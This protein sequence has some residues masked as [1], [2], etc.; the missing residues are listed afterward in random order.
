MDFSK[1][2]RLFERACR[3]A[4]GG[5]NSPVRAFRSVGGNPLFVSQACG[6]R[7]ETADG[8]DLIDF[9]GSWGPLILGHAHPAVVEAISEAAQRGT[10]FGI[11]T[12]G[13]VE[14]AEFLCERIPY[15][16]KIRLVNSGTE[17]VMTGIRLARGFTGRNLLIKFAGG[18]HGHLDALLVEAGSGLLTGGTGSSA[19]VPDPVASDTFVAPFNDL[20]AVAEIIRSRGNEL[21]A[22]I[23]EP[24]AGNMGLVPPQDGFLPGLRR[25]CDRVGALLI[26]D[27]VITGFRLGPTTY[28][29]L[30]GVR[31][32]LTAL[33]KIIGGGLPIGAIGGRGDIMDHLAPDGPVYQAG[34]LSGNPVAVAAG[35]A[36]LRT[37]VATDPYAL[38][39][40][41]ASRLAESVNVVAEDMGLPMHVA[42]LGGM[43]TPFH[44]LPP[45]NDQTDA[46]RADLQAFRRFWKTMLRESIYLPPSQFEVAFVS[47]AHTDPDID[48]TIAAMEVALQATADVPG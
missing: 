3:V 2:E 23:V 21:A 43:F 9:C 27:E 41:K 7:I 15:L 24:V 13:E 28:G 31:P 12:E 6:A 30:V 38:L 45:V 40:D 8:D 34:T 1:S 46:K 5:V 48:E 39:A 47:A 18:Y 44:T 29:A 33:G 20:E 14:L 17:A 19:G 32:D 25:L 26:F 16:E 4:P 22:V 42:T 36:T 11:P 10:S 37:L 35:L